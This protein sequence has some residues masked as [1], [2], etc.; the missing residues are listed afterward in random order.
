MNGK[1]KRVLV[2]GLDGALPCLL[3]KFLN[4]GE[5]PNIERI[6]SKGVWGEAYPCPPTDTPTNWTTIA[7]GAFVGT[8]GVTSFYIHL[9]GESL[10][11]SQK[12]RFRSQL[13]KYCKA[14]YLWEVADEFG[15]SSLIINYPS[16][17]GT[18]LKH[19]VMICGSWPMFGVPPKL[20]R[21]GG[22]IKGKRFNDKF[23]L[24]ISGG[25]IN[26]PLVLEGRVS[27]DSIIFSIYS[28]EYV[29]KLGEWSDWI[30]V[31]FDT[32]Y[33]RITGM[34]KLK[35]L[36]IGEDNIT[37]EISDVFSIE[38]WAIPNKWCKELVTR[39]LIPDGF[40]ED[41]DYEE[42]EYVKLCNLFENYAK[43]YKALVKLVSYFNAKVT[44]LHFHLF[45][46]LNHLYLGYLYKDFPYYS[47]EM[48]EKTMA[49]MRAG[50]KLVD[51]FIGRL[52]KVV[53]DDTLIVIVSD[54]GAI[55]TWRV[56]SLRKP[57]I[58]A[59]LMVY[60]KEGDKYVIDLSKTKAYIYYEPPY[61]WVNLEG[62]EEGGIVKQSEYE[63]VRDEIIEVLKSAKDPD[64]G[65]RIVEFVSRKEEDVH[66]SKSER[67]ADTIGDVTYYLKPPY[68]FWD[69]DISVLF[70]GE[71]KKE[72]YEGSMVKPARK[73]FGTHAYYL[74]TTEF[75]EF[76]I[77]G[78][79]IMAGPGIIKGEELKEPIHLADIV[80]TIAYLM[81]L[82]KQADGNVLQKILT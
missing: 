75:G 53:P 55:P 63:E 23:E 60:K 8:H 58:E 68:Q 14:E 49:I 82:P 41:L 43:E 66:L 31:T 65:E 70:S 6:V 9:P 64:T 57:L 69:G 19:G 52:L 74:P 36:E 2:I 50:W 67:L 28:K 18:H 7:T 47:E 78:I 10:V 48:Y 34:F 59:G 26:I 13:A 27:K 51:K 46:G 45:D 40:Y 24:L 39:K 38:S 54:H 81:G 22:V 15:L 1:V 11:Y 30:E 12:F 33:N 4:E 76:T 80:P 5:L 79:F 21:R 35:L 62:R 71:V 44:F 25:I 3:R 77:R 61:V 32:K 72:E 29:V 42:R 16:G 20:I 56:V 17:W 73:I 37:L